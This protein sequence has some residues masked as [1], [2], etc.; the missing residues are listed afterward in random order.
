M[1][2]RSCSGVIG[3]VT[4]TVKQCTSMR[5]IPQNY[6]I[7]S[8][9][10]PNMGNLTT[11]LLLDIFARQL[12][13]KKDFHC[14]EHRRNSPEMIQRHLKKKQKKKNENKN[15]VT[16]MKQTFFSVNDL[17]VIQ[18]KQLLKMGGSRMYFIHPW[19]L[20]W[21]W[22][23]PVFNRKY[24]FTWWI[25]HCHVSFMG[26]RSFCCS[27]FPAFTSKNVMPLL[28]SSLLLL[29]GRLSLRILVENP[30]SQKKTHV[31]SRATLCWCFRTDFF[32]GNVRKTKTKIQFI[33]SST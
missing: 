9:C 11:P 26:C 8:V 27:K 21:H 10:S 2:V 22:K 24:I 28:F 25:F 13:Y 3:H 6:Y 32:I 31:F 23:I 16:W 4:P 18:L 29:I 30:A 15:H 33:Q 1:D 20:T 12:C 19:K 14:T 5:D 7:Y 17:E